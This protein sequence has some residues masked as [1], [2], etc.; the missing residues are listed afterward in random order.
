MSIYGDGPGS[1]YGTLG[2]GGASG[3][4]G[5]QY[6]ASGYSGG[7]ETEI[8][9]NEVVFGSQYAFGYG[10]FN[11][12]AVQNF[13]VPVMSCVF[14]RKSGS[15]V[16]GINEAGATMN[17]AS[18]TW[19]RDDIIQEQN[20][21]TITFTTPLA[22]DKYMVQPYAYAVAGSNT[23]NIRVYAK[24]A[25]AITLCNIPVAAVSNPDFSLNYSNQVVQVICYQILP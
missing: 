19:S 25:S 2:D 21:C 3:L 22:N 7:A 1:N 23:D 24:S 9:Q 18:L 11:G 15:S 16:L 4:T 6:Q 10:I 5:I 13:P 17:V 14:Q 20:R 12:T 8:F